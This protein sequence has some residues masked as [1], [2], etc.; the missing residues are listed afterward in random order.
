[1]VVVS[2]DGFDEISPCAK[3]SVYE[4]NENGEEKK[5]TIDPVEFGISGCRADELAGGTGKE[6]AQL[7]NDLLEGRGRRTLR[8]AVALNGGAALYIGGKVSS[9]KD[10]YSKIIDAFETGAVKKELESIREVSNA[11]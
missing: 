10:G 2:D 1:M 6:N 11:A 5:Y 4:I 9:I 8:E 3:T 7:A